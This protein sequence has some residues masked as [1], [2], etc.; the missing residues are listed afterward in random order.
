MSS[1]SQI[2]YYCKLLIISCHSKC[3]T[4]LAFSKSF[5]FSKVEKKKKIESEREKSNWSTNFT[6]PAPK[7]QSTAHGLIRKKPCW[8]RTWKREKKKTVPLLWRNRLLPY[9]LFFFFC[10]ITLLCIS[11][12]K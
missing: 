9:Y 1:N 6:N 12:T 8:L 4:P 10:R 7:V 5:G 2:I 11:L 3:L